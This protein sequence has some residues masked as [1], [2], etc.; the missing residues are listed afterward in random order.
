MEAYTGFAGVY[1]SFMDDTPYAQWRDNIVRELKNYG[2]EDGLVLELGCGTGEMT[3]LLSEASYDMIGV[4]ASEEML[5]IAMDKRADL[6]LDILYLRQDMREFELYGTVRA[7]VSVCDSINYLL[8]DDDILKCFR[9]VD[10]Y[11]D[12][13]GIFM[14]D[15]N[16]KYK[17]QMIGEATIA[18]NR[19]DCSFIW[20]NYY[21]DE[22]CINEYG[23]T[24]FE[25]SG[26]KSA[27]G[28]DIFFRFYEEHM[29]RGYSLDE[30]KELIERSGLLFV[31][32]YDADTL[33]D[34]TDESERV[35]CVAQ[36]NKKKR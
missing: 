3:G 2:V 7:V 31:K 21:D 34:V 17:Y 36:E 23:L 26:E 22:S 18:E 35:Y 9:L 12:P 29:Q 15:F 16:T 20:E 5:S 11:L 30:M 24:I 8:S 28:Q 33:G 10:N 25:K 14:F 19:E 4:D 1:D 32:A 27:D 13:G 6:G